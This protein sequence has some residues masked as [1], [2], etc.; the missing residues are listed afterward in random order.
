MQS[1]P[2]KQEPILPMEFGGFRAPKAWFKTLRSIGTTRRD[3]MSGIVREA[4]SEW[5]ERHQ[6]RAQWIRTACVAFLTGPDASRNADLI[7]DI[8]VVDQRAREVVRDLIRRVE[9]LESDRPSGA[10]PFS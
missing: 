9:A 8:E 5:A 1:A 2:I 4:L 3:G 10:D 6:G 7:D